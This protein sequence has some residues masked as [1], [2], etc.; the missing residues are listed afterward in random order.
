M[1]VLKVGEESSFICEASEILEQLQRTHELFGS[2]FDG[3]DHIVGA[4]D[5]VNE[6]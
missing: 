5:K 2:G 3:R 4:W 6:F 1:D